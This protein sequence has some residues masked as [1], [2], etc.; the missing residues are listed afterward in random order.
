MHTLSL[1]MRDCLQ[2]VAQVESLSA[3]AEFEDLVRRL[4]LS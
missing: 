3:K 4:K 1:V 2:D